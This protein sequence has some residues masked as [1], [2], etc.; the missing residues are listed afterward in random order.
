MGSQE[1]RDETSQT[2][3]RIECRIPQ[4]GEEQQGD[5]ATRA[6]GNGSKIFFSFGRSHGGQSASYDSAGA[7][8]SAQGWPSLG[9]RDP[10]VQ[11]SRR[12]YGAGA[13][14]GLAWSGPMRSGYFHA[15]RANRDSAG[16]GA[17]YGRTGAPAGWKSQPSGQGRGSRVA[18]SYQQRG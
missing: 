16:Q 13:A 8:G 12:S 4:S 10:D 11:I 15:E 17:P 5:S 6:S 14:S 3:E 2:R 1:N 18:A 9:M 7:T